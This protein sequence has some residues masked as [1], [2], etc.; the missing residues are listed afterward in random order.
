[1]EKSIKDTDHFWAA[2]ANKL[3]SWKKKWHT[4]NN[5]DLSIPRVEWF[6]G[7]EL[8]ASYNC[9]D[10]HIENGK[11]EKT[12]LIW[13]GE[14][15]ENTKK[16]SY[17][18]LHKKVCRF[19]NILK[20]LGVKKGN[21]ITI[22]LPMIPEII[23][24]VLACS[25]IGATHNVVFS[26]LS[27]ESLKNRITDCNS[28]ILITANDITRRGET[29]PLKSK[30]E[31]VLSA[32]GKIKTC[33]VIKNG[34]CECKMIQGRD[35]W[36]HDLDAQEKIENYCEPETMDSN[37]PLFLLYTSGS[38][39][40]PKGVI[41]ST[42]GYLT[43]A[44]HTT[45]LVFDLKDEDVYWCTADI[46][47]ITG[48]TYVIYGPLSLGGTTLIF[49]GV[50]TWP[51]PDSYWKIIEKHKVNIFYTAPTAIR[52]LRTAGDKW[53]K[54]QNLNS[55]RLLGSVGEPIGEE[56]WNWYHK[57]VGREK[58]P[59]IDTW[60]QT[61]TG[62]ALISAIPNV[63]KLKPGSAT[64]PLPGIKPKILRNE[65]EE[66]N[67]DEVGQLVIEKPWPGMLTG[68]FGNKKGFKEIYFDNKNNFFKTGDVAAKDADGYFWI[69][70]RFDD[71]INVSGHRLGTAE[72]E[73]AFMQHPQVNEVA[74]IGIPHEIKGQAVHAYISPSSG[75]D[76]K[77]DLEI[78][79]KEHIRSTIGPIAKPEKI[80]FV[81]GLPKTR[82]GKIMRRLLQKIATNDLKNLG[83]IST[84]E[85]PS[86]IEPFLNAV[87]S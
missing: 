28:E 71:V 1:M 37:D 75:S 72:L 35:F 7:G 52:L 21:R 39:G 47:W 3:I 67:V 86:V 8:N 79:L 44:A 61:E 76:K 48:H 25:R 15:F 31:K 58:T 57:K 12:A 32:C 50:P 6:S 19:T 64:F 40:K 33:I 70:G 30:L 73:A 11:G 66:T 9:L 18:S 45:K 68:I 65:T 85:N 80:T 46:G 38:T 34:D 29:K 22:Y 53:L 59:I 41:H 42:G 17:N 83:D 77:L 55:L 60:W 24:A 16:Y 84:L 87:Q 74:V 69:L 27:P 4:V 81:S 56:V 49:E 82:S 23:I 36:L 5:C 43:Y 78:E 62:G 54:N 13:Q 26:G 63:T 2:Q 14:N 10:R 51:N 20:N